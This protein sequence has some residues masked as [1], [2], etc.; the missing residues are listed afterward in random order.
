MR[1]I[2]TQREVGK[3]WRES[4]PETVSHT[5]HQLSWLA[6]VHLIS[7]KGLLSVSSFAHLLPSP[8]LASFAHAGSSSSFPLSSQDSLPEPAAQHH[9]RP[10]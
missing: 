3:G 4:E 6:R 5:V 8:C 2:E 1:E 7:L 10:C 9:L